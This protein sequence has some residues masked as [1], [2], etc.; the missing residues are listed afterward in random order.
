MRRL[1]TATIVAAALALG[2]PAGASALLQ[3]AFATPP[4]LPTLT[5]IT[6]AGKTQTTNTKMTNFAIEDTR[7]LKSGW[8]VTVQ[9][10][11]GSGKS[12]VF[13]QY[14]GKAK[15]GADS[16]GYVAGGQMLAAESL[17]LNT[18]GASLTGGVGST[19]ALQCNGG[20][21]V[22]SSSAV[23]VVSGPSGLSA[24]EGT[25]TTTGF[26]AT[27]LALTTPAV[28]RT[29]ANEEVYRLNILWTLN[30]GP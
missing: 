5:T 18:T 12:A 14:C 15:C 17:T 11:S 3:L 27:S 26:S 28:L 2:W 16:E 1:A 20:C 8:N 7:V 25:W 22:D 21:A 4:A 29:L 30:S 10:Q 24:S 13:A 9:A 23:K 19:P 6:L